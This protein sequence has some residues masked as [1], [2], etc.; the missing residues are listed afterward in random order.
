MKATSFAKVIAAKPIN[1][2]I[3]SSPCGLPP[4]MVHFSQKFLFPGVM[5]TGR[6]PFPQK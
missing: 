1:T 4:L 5:L 2:I 6:S 3:M